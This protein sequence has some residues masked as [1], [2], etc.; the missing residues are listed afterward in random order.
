MISKKPQST[1]W[2]AKRHR[3]G[4]EWESELVAYWEVYFDPI[5]DDYT[6]QE[7]SAEE[8]FNLWVNKVKKIYPNGLIPILWLAVYKGKPEFMPFQF[9]SNEIGQDFLTHYTWPINKETGEQV[10]WLALPV[11]DKRW[12]DKQA[13]KG[14]FIQEFTGWKPGILQPYVYLPSLLQSRETT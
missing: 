9:L 3:T 14:G 8:L 10:N 5:S 4:R 6:P 2:K 7:I 11:V 1:I 13:N 12:N